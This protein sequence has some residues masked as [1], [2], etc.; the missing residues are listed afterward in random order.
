MVCLFHRTDWADSDVGKKWDS[1]RVNEQGNILMT[2]VPVKQLSNKFKQKNWFFL[3]GMQINIG[4]FVMKWGWEASDIN[5][6]IYFYI[7]LKN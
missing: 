4:F 2:E 3:H 6:Y 7:D 5:I 1:Y